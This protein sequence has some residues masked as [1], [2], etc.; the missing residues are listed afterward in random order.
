MTPL[1]LLRL[2]ALLSL[3]LPF[4]A[5]AAETPETPAQ[6]DERMRW[7]R[8]A[9]FGM[10]IHWG[11]Y[12][13]PAGTWD[14]KQID[15]IGEWIQLRA[16][17]PVADYAA[18]AKQFN[19]VKY[20]ADAWVRL[21]KEAG[22]KYIVITS[23]HHDGF[24]L[25]K[26]A[27]S[28]FNIVDATP[29]KRDA[30][31]ELADACQKH[32]MKLGFYYSQ[33]QDWHHPGGA[34]RGGPWDDAQ[35]GSMDDYIKNVA[36]PQV[37]EILTKYGPVAV[38][39]WDTPE[40]MNPERA[41][42]LY[43][44]IKLQPGIITNNRLGGGYMGDT[45]TPEQ[46]I[47]ATGYPRDWESCMTMNKTWGFKSYDHEWKSTQTLVRNLV[48]IA[49]KGGN[50]LLNVGP[51][52]GGEIPEPSIKALKEIGGWL[53][54][55]GEAVY[56]TTASPFRRLSWGRATQK[57]G[58]L[59]LHIFEWPKD[60]TLLVPMR[61][62]AKRAYLLKDPNTA[63]PFTPSA[64]G[65]RLT[66]KGAAPDPIDSIVVLEGVD[67]VDALPPPAIG[68]AE[69]GT[70]HLPCDAADLSG[71]HVR[72]E[73][74]TQ[75]NL[76]HW[77]AADDVAKWDV[78]VDQAAIYEVTLL[79]AASEASAGN[80][81]ALTVGDRQLAG[82]TEATGTEYKSFVLGKIALDKGRTDIV[83]KP[84][85]APRQELMKLRA[86]TLKIANPKP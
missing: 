84:T 85:S 63:V 10:F 83:L 58:K 68:A 14:G 34:A 59:F 38:L 30:L 20:D 74:N 4:V 75:L 60:G 56:A 40:G 33:A 72:V 35:K 15:G 52:A 86:V 45:E 46:R 21:A 73:G 43:P 64:E 76:G 62:G 7:W 49:S 6:R 47:P 81:F 2:L 70:L 41:G 22:M 50:Y 55:N 23:K 71:P 18:L 8:E 53:R 37:K 66:L 9:R 65:L 32:G 82:K 61:S 3:G 57:P 51:T 78:Q 39:W 12:A 16:K 67:K 29:F 69:D 31:K 24:A 79:Y 5:P 19:P 77:R 48:D 54:S 13:V 11:L 27:A 44:L 36:V 17:I 25:F 80:E 42:M 28:D 26:S 1:P